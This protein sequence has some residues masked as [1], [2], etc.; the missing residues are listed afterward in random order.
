M[1]NN[2]CK[3][4]TKMIKEK[5]KK[6]KTWKILA[7]IFM[8]LSVLF[9][10]LYFSDGYLITSRTIRYDND[11]EIDNCGGNNCNENN[12]NI[13][14]EKENNNTNIVIIVSS[15]I[16]TGGIIIGCH[17]ISSRDNHNT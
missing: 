4:C 9:A 8:C 10:I 12:G 13:I 15:I 3:I 5:Y 11:V 14:I 6:Y 7:I 16:L 2:E 17:I 1:D